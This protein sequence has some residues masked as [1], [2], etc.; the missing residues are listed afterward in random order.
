MI[1][2]LFDKKE[3]SKNF[4][5]TLANSN[6]QVLKCFK[7]IIDLD[8]IKKNIG[9]IIMTIL[10]L[11]LFILLGLSWKNHHNQIQTFISSA[12]HSHAFN[13]SEEKVGDNKNQNQVIRRKSQNKN[14]INPKKSKVSNNFQ[15]I[16]QSYS[17]KRRKKSLSLKPRKH[18]NIK[19]NNSLKPDNNKIKRK[20]SSKKK[21]LHNPPKYRNNKKSKSIKSG[22]FSRSTLRKKSTS[23][24]NARNDNSSIN[25]I[26]KV[27]NS[28][29]REIN[30][31]Q[32]IK[33]IKEKEKINKEFK[34]DI[35]RSTKKQSSFQ[36]II[37]DDKKNFLTK[38]FNAQELNSLSYDMALKYDNRTYC[39][40]Y[41]SLLK[42]KQLILFAFS[43]TN[44]YNLNTIKIS[45]FIISFSLYFTI[46]GFFFTDDTMHK[47]Y[48]DK[49]KFNLF[50]HLPQILYSTLISSLINIILKILSLSEKDIISIKEQ[51]DIA[52]A[53]EKAKIIELCIKIKFSIFFV[54]AIL[55]MIFFWYF[56]SCFCAVYKNT[57]I[58][59]IKDTLISFGLSMIYPFGLNLLPG[60]F[61]IPALRA[62]NKDKE[63][64][65]K[66]SLILALI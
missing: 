6:F 52:K 49:G 50:Y 34:E 38:S 51:N 2:K 14:T 19:L 35:R 21:I 64:L 5:K 42:K 1:E 37:V 61:R 31:Y 9:E 13:I 59:L 63:T 43:I 3:I 46:N 40:Y 41:W 17:I 4:Y 54:L 55:F 45:L 12:I 58:I 8:K 18:H 32:Y 11:I 60:F 66:F 65:Y 24:K 27:K 29:E 25:N 56:I 33:K 57:Q 62:A 7:L 39:Q 16:E 44:D 26:Y 53:R 10:L 47:V 36:K 28:T 48:E 23:I 15:K 30:S 22:C 20:H